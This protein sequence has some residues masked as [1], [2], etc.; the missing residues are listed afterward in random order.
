MLNKLFKRTISFLLAAVMVFGYLPFANI[1]TVS[2]Y[3]TEEYEEFGDFEDFEEFE[4][5]VEEI[6]EVPSFINVLVISPRNGTSTAWAQR[7]VGWVNGRS[8]ATSASGMRQNIN[9][10][11]L[12]PATG[13]MRPVISFTTVT[14]QT[15]FANNYRRLMEEF[16]LVDGEYKYDVIVIGG[17]HLG[18]LSVGRSGNDPR[19]MTE[20][21]RFMEAGG[22]VLFGSGMLADRARTSR[23]GTVTSAQVTGSNSRPNGVFAPAPNAA[24]SSTTVANHSGVNY[25]FA[26]LAHLAGVIPSTQTARLAHQETRVR[27]ADVDAPILTYPFNLRNQVITVSG[28]AHSNGALHLTENGGNVWGQFVTSAAGITLS[29]R[30]QGTNLPSAMRANNIVNFPGRT[31]REWN[32]RHQNQPYAQNA[33]QPAGIYWS[34]SYL[35][36]FEGRINGSAHTYRTAYMQVSNQDIPIRERELFVNVLYWLAG[37]DPGTDFNSSGPPSGFTVIR[38]EDELRGIDRNAASRRGKYWLANDIELTRRWTPISDFSG[39]FL[40]N[41]HTISNLEINSTLSN[42]GLFRKTSGGAVIRDLNIQVSDNGIRGNK[43]VGALIG[44]ARRTTVID[45]SVEIGHNGVRGTQKVG[46]LIGKARNSTIIGGYS[47]GRNG[48]IEIY[49]NHPEP[50]N[51]FGVRGTHQKAGGLIGC[52]WNSTLIESTSYLNVTGYR[53]IGG[54]VGLTK[55]STI[56]N[57]YARGHVLGRRDKDNRSG[58]KIGG[59]IGKNHGRTTIY[60][61]YASGV[62]RGRSHV[63]PLIGLVKGTFTSKGMS[64]YDGQVSQGSSSTTQSMGSIRNRRVTRENTANMMTQGTFEFSAG[65]WDF[66]RIWTLG[67][68]QGT[69]QFIPTYPHFRGRGDGGVLYSRPPIIHEVLAFA[70]GISGMGYSPNAVIRV[71]LPDGNVLETLT[72]AELRWF[73]SVPL[74]TFLWPDDIITA[75]QQEVGRN[76][77]EPIS[78]TVRLFRFVEL[79][80]EIGSSNLTDEERDSEGTGLNF[81]GDTIRYRI[82]VYNE[83]EE[84][85]FASNIA[86]TNILPEGVSFVANSVQLIVDSEDD[87][88]VA[89]VP[90][91][92]GSLSSLGYNYEEETGALAIHLG[93]LRLNGGESVA[94]E[95]DVTIDEFTGGTTIISGPVHITSGPS[96]NHENNIVDVTVAEEEGR[97]V[98]LSHINMSLI[99]DIVEEEDIDEDDTVLEPV[100]EYADAVEGDGNS[101]ADAIVK[102]DEEL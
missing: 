44:Y 97:F 78:T 59:L 17:Y 55:N 96:I 50:D 92:A 93:N 77:S 46:G 91:R 24:L 37:V 56:H 71:T 65:N 33:L 7:I 48:M 3:G 14:T 32:N 35:N 88:I 10:Q 80:A 61:V 4:E 67:L 76:E 68:N 18:T 90:R 86:L 41:G 5:F 79:S 64:F 2:A 8:A 6:S 20:L 9:P 99:D 73:V 12:D 60:N 94:I 16:R 89:R 30:N 82:V 81:E 27:L 26:P 19:L 29:S 70:T 62:V 66:D 47:Y 25:Y 83:G 95:F 58:T 84:E 98:E 36:T 39:I 23:T 85:H 40:G 53:K 51:V 34:N 63:N 28:R 74:G 69:S 15:L 21:Y 72:D 31:I 101:D 42:R 1:V 11:V 13:R 87:E 43:R 57:S 45:V 38:T 52:L 75:T 22:G 100:Y 102:E 54:L 49:D